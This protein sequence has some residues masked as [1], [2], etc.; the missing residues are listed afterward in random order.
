MTGETG[1]TL[2][3]VMLVVVIMTIVLMIAI[4]GVRGRLP[5]IYLD[6]AQGNVFAELRAARMLAI[7]ESRSVL[8]EVDDANVQLLVKVDRD[9]SGTYETDET[10]VLNFN[11]SGDITVTVNATRGTFDP[12][13][14]FSCSNGYWRIQIT[15][16]VAGQGYVYVLPS[17]QVLESDESL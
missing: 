1:F 13:G 10:T 6:R 11:E 17:G 15:S 8:T 3:E 16:P 7:S 9:S 14:M 5:Y 4:P 12:R 2:T